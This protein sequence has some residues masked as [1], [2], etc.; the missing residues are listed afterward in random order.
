MRVW[1]GISMAVTAGWLAACATGTAFTRPPE[2]FARLGETTRAQVQARL[3]KPNAEQTTRR[4]GLAIR[5]IQY[6][7]SDSA[8]QSKVPNSLCV[9]SITFA[10]VDDVVFAEAFVS[11]CLSDHTDFDER[12][13]DRVVK[14]QT[15]C[16]DVPAVLGRPAYRAISPVAGA[17]GESEI[18]YQ[19]MFMRRPLL[20]LDMYSKELL[21]HCDAQGVVREVTFTESGQR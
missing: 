21:I 20:Q 6:T 11:A 9:R 15:R 1:I 3:G 17:T 12:S 13:A 19:F 16:A 4:D 5:M 7:F 14:G 8:E 18:G 10:L 2:E